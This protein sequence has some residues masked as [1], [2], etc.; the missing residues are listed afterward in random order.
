MHA[1]IRG[2][3]LA[4]GA[5]AFCLALVI[6]GPLG[7]GLDPDSMSYVSAA[8]SL[9]Q[10]GQLLVPD[11][12]WQ[13]PDSTTALAHFP[14]GLPA[15]LAV[16]V[17]LG[18]PAEQGARLVNAASAFVTVAVV[19]WLVSGAVGVPAG[20][21][22]GITIL[23]T[24]AI[25]MVHE[26]I[27]SEPLFLALLVLLVALM[28]RAPRHP[29]L[30]GVV[31]AAASLVRY[32]GVSAIA[33]A[34][35]WWLALPGNSGRR[36][37]AAV[38]AALPGVV[39]QALWVLRTT[40]VNGGGSIRQ[41]S[42]YGQLGSTVREGANTVAAWL[43]PLLD[44]AWRAAA[45]VAVLVAIVVLIVLAARR[46]WTAALLEK[47]TLTESRAA[48]LLAALALLA[49]MY[50]GLVVASRLFADPGI[51]LDQRLLVPLILIVETGVIVALAVEWRAWRG[52]RVWLR[53]LAAATLLAWWG[54]SLSTTVDDASYALDT[55]NDYADASWRGSPLI[56]WVRAHADGRPLVT[57]FPTAL[58]FH[59][60]RMARVP[61]EQT[62]ARTLQAFADTLARRHA[63]LV[64]FDRTSEFVPSTDSFMRKLP[65]TL[66][67]R[68]NDGS[69]WEIGGEGVASRSE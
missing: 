56:A 2:V 34:A 19:V 54:A 63:L 48:R 58:Y 29:L 11:D 10:R 5:A 9:V 69:V 37:R 32:A 24:P 31:A 40:H 26:S 65:L 64:I 38:L 18:M 44:G 47:M 28:A 62:D 4:F 27:L 51:P 7:P 12:D 14:P 55:G 15:A 20:V 60:D 1:T 59:A 35:L 22:A 42:M 43:A 50:V 13:S 36:A 52:V 53:A 23:V 33:A 3:A 61:P 30:A 41:I 68:E 8:R 49:T 66:V 57:N 21:A 17:A 16:P 25:A 46:L 67:A 45:A 6:T 39:A